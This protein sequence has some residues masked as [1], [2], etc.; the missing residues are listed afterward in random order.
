MSQK[1]ESCTHSSEGSQ[2]E[3]EAFH[4]LGAAS[5]AAVLRSR[6]VLGERPP[7]EQPTSER[8][9]DDEGHLSDHGGFLLW[10]VERLDDEIGAKGLVGFGC[11]DSG[12]A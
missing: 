5:A 4:S 6:T 11:E 1:S 10:H 9:P 7:G 2:E 12:D 8:S 3:R